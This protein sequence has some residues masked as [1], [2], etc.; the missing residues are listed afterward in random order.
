MP[1]RPKSTEAKIVKNMLFRLF[2]N[3]AS[4]AN[5]GFKILASYH[6]S[7]Q[8]TQAGVPGLNGIKP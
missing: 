5:D 7:R 2:L 8:N 4:I 6:L 1:K 3:S